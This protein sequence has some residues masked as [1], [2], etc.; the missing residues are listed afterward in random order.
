MRHFGAGAQGAVDGNRR[1]LQADHVACIDLAIDA[2]RAQ[3]GGRCVAADQRADGQRVDAAIG[4]DHAVKELAARCRHQQAAHVQRAGSADDHAVRIG[5]HDIAADASILQAVDDA[6]DLDRGVRDQV[7]QVGRI[8]GHHQVDRIVLPH[9][10]QVEGIERRLAV[11]GAGGDVGHVAGNGQ[12]GGRGPLGHDGVLRVR[13]ANRIAE[14]CQQG[15][16]Q[17]RRPGAVQLPATWVCG[18][19]SLR[20]DGHGAFL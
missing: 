17:R 11:D 1:A 15:H 9:L 13:H 16:E 19:E 2:D 12:L 6:V 7:D 14:Y 4:A 18:L 20:Q 5:K 3:A 10:E 8:G